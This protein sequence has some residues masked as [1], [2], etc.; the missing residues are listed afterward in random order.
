MKSKTPLSSFHVPKGLGR[1]ESY[2]VSLHR[3]SDKGEEQDNIAKKLDL[4]RDTITA[5]AKLMI[6]TLMSF[7]DPGN[8]KKMNEAKIA[9]I[10]KK[11]GYEPSETSGQIPG[12][13]YERLEEIGIRL[14][15]R[16]I[17]FYYQEEVGREK[18]KISKPG[19]PLKIR[20][21]IRTRENLLDINPLQTFG[22]YYED[23]K[24][25]PIDLNKYQEEDLIKYESDID[26]GAPIYAIPLIDNEGN[27][28]MKEDGI[29]PRRKRA[30]GVKWRWNTDFA[31]WSQDKQNRWLISADTIPILRKYLTKPASINLMFLIIFWNKSYFEICQDK[32]IEH[33]GITGTSNPA[34]VNK[35]IDTAF[36]DAFN[37]GFIDQVRKREPGYY[38]VT[39][40]TGR[41]RRKNMTYLIT[42]SK[43]YRLQDK[44]EIPD[45]QEEANSLTDKDFH[46]QPES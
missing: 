3:R 37:E 15:R 46:E 31:E 22:F 43:K 42:K 39:K 12:Y 16:A 44:D 32:L 18:K 41:P 13:V 35:S 1:T 29:T 11:M 8:L 19:E 20:T 27:L 21:I 9:D 24:G 36:Q 33:L 45:G 2:L 14:R 7:S 10:A 25:N 26:D 38:P 28:V 30:N 23:E 40:K 4:F 5:S 17:R 6:M 34:Q